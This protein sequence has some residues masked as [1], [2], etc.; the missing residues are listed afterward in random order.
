VNYKEQKT[1][2]TADTT[3]TKQVAI[4]TNPDSSASTSTSH[5]KKQAMRDSPSIDTATTRAIGNSGDNSKPK[6][7][8]NDS[9][10]KKE[11]LKLI[12]KGGTKDKYSELYKSYERKGSKNTLNSLKKVIDEWDDTYSTKDKTEMKNY[13]KINQ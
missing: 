6:G 4:T 2:F 11:I 8:D 7:T 3:E 9:I 5:S 12:E 13:F 1:T 10:L